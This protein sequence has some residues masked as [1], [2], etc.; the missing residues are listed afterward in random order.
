ML[1]EINA[2]PFAPLVGY[3]SAIVASM[4]AIWTLLWRQKIWQAPQNLLPTSLRGMIIVILSVG[5]VSIWLN[6]EPTTLITSTKLA[7]ILASSAML[8]FLLYFF[9]LRICSYDKEVA[10]GPNK[11]EIIKIIGGFNLLNEAKKEMGN[12]KIRTVQ[13]LFKG[14]LYDADLLWSRT[15]Q[16]VARICIMLCFIA[17]A[18]C[19]TL[20]LTTAGFI[21][22]V[23]LTG[24]PAA[25]VIKKET[26]PGLSK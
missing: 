16:E 21:T 15:S 23:R 18:V 6:I 17:I 5:M 10:V 11:T 8:S 7:A 12:H 24:K 2:G 14:S 20:A 22:Q 25:E 9:L 19:G 1:L 26:P 3:A 13:E 4:Y